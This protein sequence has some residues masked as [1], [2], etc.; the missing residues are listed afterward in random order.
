MQHFLRWKLNAHK[1]KV[2]DI[3]KFIMCSRL[4]YQPKSFWLCWTKKNDSIYATQIHDK[5]WHSFLFS[6]IEA[7]S[8]KQSLS[9]DVH[10]IQEQCLT[11]ILV[12]NYCKNYSQTIK[13]MHQNITFAANKN[14]SRSP[15]M[16][17]R[18]VLTDRP[19]KDQVLCVRG[20]SSCVC[21][22]SHQ[23]QILRRHVNKIAL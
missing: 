2:H 5:L 17:T 7:N 15:Q 20:L 18:P 21:C 11:T 19:R 13:N 16:K 12:K 3:S 1:R 9:K 14:F 6:K 4:G 10:F 8:V 22:G 23:Q